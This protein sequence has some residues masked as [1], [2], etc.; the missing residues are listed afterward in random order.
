M[1]GNTVECCENNGVK[2]QNGND[3]RLCSAI[4]KERVQADKSDKCTTIAGYTQTFWDC[5]DK[6]C[7]DKAP[8]FDLDYCTVKNIGT[9]I[10]QHDG[11]S[12]CSYPGTCTYD[13][14]I[15]CQTHQKCIKYSCQNESYL[16]SMT[17]SC[18]AYPYPKFSEVNFFL[19][20]EQYKSWEQSKKSS[21]ATYSLISSSRIESSG[22]FIG[23]SCI[24]KS[25][26]YR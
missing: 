8:S 12:D 9:H 25:C 18:P 4:D 19:H 6:Y 14:T 16:Y 26:D 22:K 3:L 5:K 10:H 23:L 11:I 21:G 20:P 2:D 13:A 15:T 1:D 7:S 17:Q 24:Y